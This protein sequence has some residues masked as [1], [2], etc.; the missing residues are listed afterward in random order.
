MQ[1]K[2]WWAATVG[3]ALLAGV[4]AASSAWFGVRAWR[5]RLPTPPSRYG[6]ST[7][8]LLDLASH[9]GLASRNEASFESGNIGQIEHPKPNAYVLN[10]RSDN[11][12]A[13]PNWW[14]QWF[15]LRLSD[16]PVGQQVSLTLQGAGFHNSYLP[17]YSY[18]N[19]D[20]IQFADSAVTQPAPSVL[21]FTAAFA[22]RTVWLAR[23]V[24]YPYSRMQRFI[25]QFSGH[26]AA[27][28][29][30]I[31]K[32][33]QGRDMP[34]LTI[35][36]PGD[37]SRKERVV[38]HARTHPGEVASSFLLEGL[39]SFLLGPSVRAEQLRSHLVFTILP[40][41]NIDGVVAGNN[42]V[43]PQGINLE[44]TWLGLAPPSLALDPLRT[45]PEVQVFH[46]YLERLLVAGPAVTMALN[47]HASAGEPKNQAFAFAHFGSTAH[48]FTAFEAELYNK[49]IKFIKLLAAAQ[50]P[51]WLTGGSE[52][53]RDFL[54]AQIPERWWWEHFGPRVTA[55][56][57][58]STYG[59]AGDQGRWLKP[60]DLR[61]FGAAVGEAIGRF[62][63]A[64]DFCTASVVKN[65]V[66]CR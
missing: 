29:S 56:T 17:F 1:A 50:G 19:V 49:Q 28:I 34:V 31:G 43:T 61:A 55:L 57:F 25:A 10:L 26:P 38:I 36:A 12:D 23:Y 66:K 37:Q 21:V 13:L 60:N 3:L 51:A 27:Q 11:D 63:F 65:L 2:R 54:K 40:M 64:S 58:E 24:P 22:Q 33:P 4:C 14:R 42:R 16:V 15:Y 52:G 46:K 30:I 41:L 32:T 39:I 6:T 48:G 18:N 20:W 53:G 9:A 47:L 35:T 5:A 7:Q 44:G 8:A 59:L 45:P 62:H